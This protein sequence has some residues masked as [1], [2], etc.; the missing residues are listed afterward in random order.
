[1]RLF[2][3][4]LPSPDA[5][6]EL[7]RVVASLRGLP[8][9]EALRWTGRDGWHLTLAFMGEVE[10]RLV[11]ELTERLT[12]GARRSEP[13]ALR[14]RGGGHFGR[15]ALWAGV[16]AGAAATGDTEAGRGKA[17]GELRRLAER[18]EAAGRRAGVNMDE[19]PAYRPHLTLARS[20]AEGTDLRPHV[21]ALDGF[22]GTSWQVTEVVL[23]HS[24]LP[25]GRT[26][27]AGPRY[28]TLAR[29]PL[30]RGGGGPRGR[31]R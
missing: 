22:E 24:T 11:P 31:G 15:R 30:G 19:R 17:L 27:G 16:A 10:E 9:A 12:R 1:V 13:F 18:A 4:V 7:D 26:P 23:V 21:E 8:G 14:L 2:A 29:C 3:A 20:R 28:A 6:G 5:V 25:D